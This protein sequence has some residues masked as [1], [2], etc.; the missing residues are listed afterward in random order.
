[1]SLI[2]EKF[3]FVIFWL[4]NQR[5]NNILKDLSRTQFTVCTKAVHTEMKLLGDDFDAN[6]NQQL[7]DL[8]Q[9]DFSRIPE[10]FLLSVWTNS[11][12]V[13]FAY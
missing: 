3:T 11:L 8:P 7:E 13:N 4:R 10:R 2:H 12:T 1:M 9:S 5:S 6:E